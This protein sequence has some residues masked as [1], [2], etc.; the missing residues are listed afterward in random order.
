VDI[1][2]DEFE[3]NAQAAFVGICVA[4][5]SQPSTKSNQ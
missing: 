3:G 5:F 4:W 1:E 2:D